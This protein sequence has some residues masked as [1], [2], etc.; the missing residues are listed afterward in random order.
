MLN[1]YRKHNFELQGSQVQD[2]VGHFILQDY[3]W[4][5]QDYGAQRETET[6]AE[7][8]YLSFGG[9]MKSKE[10]KIKRAYSF[11]NILFLKKKK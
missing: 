1:Q 3:I 10:L 7:E 6:L 11:V 9:I 8:K 2:T 5:Q 4:I